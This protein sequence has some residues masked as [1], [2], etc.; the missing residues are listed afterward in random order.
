MD[1]TYMYI[2]KISNSDLIAQKKKYSINNTNFYYNYNR[3]FL[4]IY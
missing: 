3:Q 4:I 1:I 2:F